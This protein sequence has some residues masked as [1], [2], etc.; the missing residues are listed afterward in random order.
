MNSLMCRRGY[1]TAAVVADNDGTGGAIRVAK[2]GTNAQGGVFYLPGLIKYQLADGASEIGCRTNQ[3]PGS[4]FA[5]G[6]PTN[7]L[8]RP[9][10][11]WNQARIVRRGAA[12]EHWLN[13][14]RA[15]QLDF[16]D[17]AG[18]ARLQE[19]ESRFYRGN[20]LGSA[21]ARRPQLRLLECGNPVA[22]R[23]LRVCA[24]ASNTPAPP[25]PR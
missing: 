23:N 24:L 15:F 11:Q 6:G 16:A 12:L 4:L 5:L 21:A 1:D 7:D 18:R 13:G 14:Q 8:S 20:S 19:I 3:R 9:A 22:F 25:T 17:P 10:G 2:V